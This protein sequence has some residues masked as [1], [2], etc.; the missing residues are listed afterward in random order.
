M[1]PAT[2]VTPRNAATVLIVRDAPAGLEV[3]LVR[4]PVRAGDIFSGACVFPGGVVDA[5]DR[6]L[7]GLCAGF[8]DAAASARL[9]LP[10]HGLDYYIAAI[11]E[12]FEEA[13]LLLAYGS[14]GRLVDLPEAQLAN[15][16]AALAAGE[17]DFGAL[18]AKMGLKL[19]ADSLAY[20]SHWLTPPDF[21]KRFD[22]RFFL[23][24]APAAQTASHDGQET[25][26]HFWLRPAE[27]LARTEELKLRDVTEDTLA[28]LTAFASAVDALQHAHGLG[29][30]TTR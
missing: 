29:T 25:V 8:D 15:M 6:K 16:R 1:V 12:C 21:A 14:D 5:T 7:H 18:C 19:A 11:R 30:I 27:A 4:R 26:Q 13:G 24:A 3:L 22:T 20:H 9:G 28:T 2:T 23:T 10:A 17:A